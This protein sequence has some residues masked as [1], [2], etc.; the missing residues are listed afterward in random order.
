VGN[1]WR[2]AGLDPTV[3]WL[4]RE[5]SKTLIDDVLGDQI[6]ASERLTREQ[7]D[8]VADATRR[9]AESLW[10]MACR[11]SQT[12]DE[13]SNMLIPAQP[14]RKALESTL[15]RRPWN[16]ALKLVCWKAGQ[17][18]VMFNNKEDCL[19][20]QLY[21][22]RK[23]YE[24]GM[25]MNLAYKEQAEEKLR[26]TKIGDD[27]IAREW[28]EKGMLPPA[29]IHARSVRWAVKLFL[30]HWH[31]RAYELLHGEPPAGPYPIAFLGHVDFIPAPE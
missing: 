4:G 18:F 5:K 6:K 10:N 30:S 11:S 13:K 3:E 9:N 27:T 28:Y 22:K 14:T 21:K 1:I 19:Y 23:E 7:V 24:Y 2:Y 25:N 8:L 16:A 15:A 20:G 31:Y 12:A 29:H 17:S 26:T